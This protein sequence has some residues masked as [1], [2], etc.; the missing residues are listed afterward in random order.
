MVNS[1]YFLVYLLFIA[2][3]VNTFYPIV[4][5]TGF[6]LN[7]KFIA[8]N[9]CINR[10]SPAIGCGGKC[11]L[12]KKLRE[13]QEGEKKQEEK[14]SLKIESLYFPPAFDLISNNSGTL[15][16]A[17]FRSPLSILLYS[18]NYLDSVF[19]PPRT[20]DHLLYM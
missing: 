11:Y 20:A 13:V 7:R 8:S 5:L 18:S 16:L 9:L 6:E 2:V 10:S 19:K 3:F 4:I 1:K 14:G 17:I 15:G 12:Q